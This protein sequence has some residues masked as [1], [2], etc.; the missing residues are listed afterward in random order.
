MACNVDYSP[1]RRAHI[2]AA[3]NRRKVTNVKIAKL[4]RQATAKRGLS[5]IRWQVETTFNN[6]TAARDE[7]LRQ[8]TGTESSEQKSDVVWAVST[9][10]SICTTDGSYDGKT[11]NVASSPR[12]LS[13]PLRVVALGGPTEDKFDACAHEW[14]CYLTVAESIRRQIESSPVTMSRRSPT[15]R[16]EVRWLAADWLAARNSGWR[17]VAVTMT[18]LNGRHQ[19]LYVCGSFNPL[20]SAHIPYAQSEGILPKYGLLQWVEYI[21]KSTQ[22]ISTKLCRDMVE[23]LSFQKNIKILVTFD[24]HSRSRDPRWPPNTFSKSNLGLKLPIT[25]PIFG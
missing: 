13:G 15:T 19:R 25:Q 21:S 18:W 6:N 3:D 24:L 4:W 17:W 12:R 14:N 23:A 1:K 5:K 7:W 11:P 20:L 2:V 10:L 22:W 9:E 16:D 8:G